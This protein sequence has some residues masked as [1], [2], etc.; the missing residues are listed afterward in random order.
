MKNL[1]LFILR[2][3]VM[4]TSCSSDDSDSP[5]NE[6]PPVSQLIGKWQQISLKEDGESIIITDCER[7]STFEFDVQS[8]SETLYV[9]GNDCQI[10]GDFTGKWEEEGDTLRLIY[11]DA[12]EPVEDVTIFIIEDDILTIKYDSERLKPEYGYK[13][14]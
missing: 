3:T 4:S 14:I 1:S 13:K 5:E 12:G 11:L 9:S 8:Y 2:I 10:I 7:K 6:N